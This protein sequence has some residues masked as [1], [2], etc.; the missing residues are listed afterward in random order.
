MF[1]SSVPNVGICNI[2]TKHESCEEQV[3]DLYYFSRHSTLIKHTTGFSS[4]SI[5]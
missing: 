5:K 3:K 4:E 1:P 2:H